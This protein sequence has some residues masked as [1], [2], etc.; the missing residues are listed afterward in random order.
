M[1]KEF[2]PNYSTL[3]LYPEQRTHAEGQDFLLTDIPQPSAIWRIV[4]SVKE[5]LLTIWR[6]PQKRR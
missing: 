4:S 3:L 2:F 6:K 5:W 1:L